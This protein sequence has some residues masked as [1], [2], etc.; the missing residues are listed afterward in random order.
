M[1]YFYEGG[2]A[3]LTFS[4]NPQSGTHRGPKGLSGKEQK[5]SI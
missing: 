4:R 3:A 5:F 2:L 1:L